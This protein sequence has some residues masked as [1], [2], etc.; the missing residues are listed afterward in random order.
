MRNIRVAPGVYLEM[1]MRMSDFFGLVAVFASLLMT[2][3][4]LVKEYEASSGVSVLLPRPCTQYERTHRGDGREVMVQYRFDHS[5]LV[6]SQLMPVEKDVRR[7][8]V[9]LMST[10]WEQAISFTADERLTYGE[11]SAVLSDLK[12]DDP[13]LFIALLTKRQFGSV[14]EMN[15]AIFNDLC[16]P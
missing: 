16:L 7:E 5:G 14:D 1:A 2:H 4:V 11:V 13:N 9:T 12:K 8:I 3:S 15:V 10:R 6:N